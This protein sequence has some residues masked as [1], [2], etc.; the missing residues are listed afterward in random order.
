M[1]FISSLTIPCPQL[2][3]QTRSATWAGWTWPDPQNVQLW[4]DKSQ[5]VLMLAWV[6]LGPYQSKLNPKSTRNV[7]LLSFYIRIIHM[8]F[9]YRYILKAC[10][11]GAAT[12][13][14][15]LMLFL[16][17]ILTS[18]YEGITMVKTTFFLRIFNSLIMF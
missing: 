10:Q 7:H 15:V 1:P 14:Q 16:K 2:D 18:I 17:Q 4:V 11:W 3:I 5:H 13:L 12:L 9:F 6:C 8:I